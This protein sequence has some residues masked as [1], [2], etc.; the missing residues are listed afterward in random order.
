ML[1][2][3]VSAFEDELREVEAFFHGSQPGSISCALMAY[4]PVDDGC[5]VSIWDLWNRFLRDLYLTSAAGPVVGISQASYQPRTALTETQ[6]LGALTTAASKRSGITIFHGEPKW[7]IA[8]SALPIA[9]ALGLSNGSQINS[10]L[11]QRTLAQGGGFNL[12]NPVLEVQSIRN[13]IA[14]KS[15]MGADRVRRNYTNGQVVSAHAR[16]RTRGGSTRF[17]D[18]CDGLASLAWDAAI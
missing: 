6:A 1:L 15:L 4:S 9:S 11:G 18:W 12:E 10:A 17:R 2:Q 16:Q 5:I 8:R 7:F 3:V 13:Y 14:H